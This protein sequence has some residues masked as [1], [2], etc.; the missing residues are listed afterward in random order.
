MTGTAAP[1]PTPFSFTIR[2]G[3]ECLNVSG[4]VPEGECAVEALVPL[5]LGVGEGIV[6]AAVRQIPPATRV[7]CGPG[8]GACCRQLVPLSL[9]EAA[10]LK[11]QVLPNLPNKHRKRVEQRIAAAAAALRG[12]KL[13]EVLRLLPEEPDPQQRQTVGVRYFL[14]GLPC[15]F[16]EHES[17]SI[18]PQRPL[19]CREYLVSSPAPHCAHPDQGGVEPVPIPQK[20]SHALI[21]LDAEL[22]H[23]PGWRTMIDVLIDAPAAPERTIPQPIDFLKNFLYHLLQS[24]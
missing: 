18:H 23:S 10:Y 17:C 9:S 16:L 12:G 6:A 20:P 7:S 13:L 21:Q 22:T 8:C 5:L 15:P 3:E 11:N 1:H 14:L 4:S 19:A 2:I 24:G